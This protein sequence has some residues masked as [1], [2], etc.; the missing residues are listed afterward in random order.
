MRIWI[1][2]ENP[3]QVQYLLP[4][5]PAF[6]QLGAEVVVTARDYGNTFELLE[7]AGV[8]FSP[9]GA[10]YGAAKWRKAAGL[11]GRT[12]QLVR[13]LRRTGRPDASVSA[14]RAAAVAGRL[15]RH[16][17]FV[18]IDYEH[19]FLGVQRLTRSYVLHPDVIEAS[20]FRDKGIRDRRARPLPRSEG[21]LVVRARERRER[22]GARP[23]NRG[24]RA[25]SRPR[26]PGRRGEPLLPRGVRPHDA[27]SAGASRRRRAGDRRLLASL[28]TAGRVPRPLR[29]AQRAAR[30][31]PRRPVR[32][33]PESRRPRRLVRRDDVARGGVSRCPR[34]QHV[35]GRRRGRRSPPR[36]PRAAPPP[37]RAL[38]TSTGC[39]S[40]KRL[41]SLRSRAIPTSSASSPKRCSAPSGPPRRMARS[42]G[43]DR[44]NG[45]RGSASPRLPSELAL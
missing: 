14:S 40:P 41:P 19:V 23:R 24:R 1:D 13:H 22:A 7:Q 27:R 3:P 43:R 15:L 30:A 18:I 25:G 29:V 36:E 35:P 44:P 11:A 6:E 17:S 45:R 37:V 10:S 12:R 21:G 42:H 32:L 16:P 31:R 9:I 5:R 39:R 26:A 8:P 33:T 28:S 4:L 38:P 2:I 20:A 34:V